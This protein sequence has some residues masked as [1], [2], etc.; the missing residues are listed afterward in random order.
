MIKLRC[1]NCHVKMAV[2]D[3]RANKPVLCPRCEMKFAVAQPI[4]ELSDAPAAAETTPSQAAPVQPASPV[5][6]AEPVVNVRPQVTT[7]RTRRRA[8]KKSTLA[9]TISLCV[10]LLIFTS[11]VCGAYY[12]I[13][14]VGIL[15][16]V[17]KQP[18]AQREPDVRQK[19]QSPKKYRNERYRPPPIESVPQKKPQEP[20]P[21][22]TPSP[23]TN[24]FQDTVRFVSLPPAEDSS[25]TSLL[26]I[27]ND[28]ILEFVPFHANLEW[29]DEKL[30]WN[31]E[32]GPILCGGLTQKDGS[33]FFRWMDEVPEEAR[34]AIA[35]SII[36]L[37]RG[38][39]HHAIALRTPQVEPQVT[40]DLRSERQFVRCNCDFRPEPEEIF[41]EITP[42]EKL[43]IRQIDGAENER[44]KLNDQLTVWFQTAHAAATRLTYEKKGQF[45]TLLLNTR[46][47]LPSGKEAPLSLGDIK[48]QE[49]ILENLIH[50]SAEADNKIDG[51][52]SYQNYLA[53]KLNSANNYQTSVMVNRQ[54]FSDFSRRV[55]KGQQLGKLQT[56]LSKVQKRLDVTTDIQA[57]R[58][59]FQQDAAEL[60]KVTKLA[61]ELHEAKAFSYCFY[62]EVGGHRVD[63][64]RSE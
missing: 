56:Q 30:I 45:P 28:V 51:L 62:H 4:A 52:E 16:G 26:Q 38:D 25:A 35:N 43:P 64:V 48:R 34:A 21:P 2:S 31:T 20:S 37:G 44:I 11:T 54:P 36:K 12:L 61:R 57:N 17:Q 22:P 40:Y 14:H 24:P 33:V 5:Q 50:S 27:A 63:L 23:E 1:P 47:K 32:D 19:S 46:Y 3:Q 7:P 10:H 58:A 8:R 55:H 13:W 9:T 29:K 39:R 15:D 41:L 18:E 53:S 6:P 49:R 42:H 60:E 59:T